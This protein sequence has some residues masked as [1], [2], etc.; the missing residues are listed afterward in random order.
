M[1][2]EVVTLEERPDL[3]DAA[4]ALGD[5]DDPLFFT[6]TG[7][8]YSSAVASKWARF[9][10]LLLQADAVVA[11][12]ST[13]PFSSSVAGRDDLPAD[14]FDGV[15]RWAAEDA[16]NERAS[17]CLAALEISV[18]V[19]SRGQG[20]SGRALA[21]VVEL[22]RANGLSEVV[23]PVRPTEKS[24]SPRM[25][26]ADYVALTRDDGLPVDPW[27]RVH[28]RAGGEIVGIAPLSMVMVGTLAQWRTWTVA[29]LDRDGEIEIP[30][31]LA[32]LIVN[33]RQN[34]AVYIEPNVWMRHRVAR[35]G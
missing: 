14:G 11:R 34:V 20:L 33:Q 10:L 9:T 13:V 35:E 7:W 21:A 6:P 1:D 23:C 25:G 24:N 2:F 3:L 4:F 22:A 32:P 29:D 19:A 26:L 12:A 17:N 5:P 16:L 30:G 31:A 18:D 15:L 28:V 27:L 8:L